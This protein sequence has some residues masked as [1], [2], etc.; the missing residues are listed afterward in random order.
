MANRRIQK[1]RAA[2]HR[3]LT[4]I[5]ISEAEV[6]RRL[7]RMLQR[8]RRR[9][10]GYL[11]VRADGREVAMVPYWYHTALV[12]ETARL[13]RLAQQAAPDSSPAVDPPETAAS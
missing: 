1:K 9:H 6:P 3:P 4:M 2:R 5:R 12:A 8:M 7:D 11:I 10:E 13:R